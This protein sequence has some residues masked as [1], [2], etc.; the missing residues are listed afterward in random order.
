MA[1]R[2]PATP[3][4]RRPTPAAFRRARAAL[5]GEQTRILR[6]SDEAR[7]REERLVQALLLDEY[8][9]VE[10]VVRYLEHAL[11]DAEDAEE[12]AHVG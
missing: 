4:L 8:T 12:M 5:L 6:L 10:S 7:L 3:A 9:E 11:D 1:D 2:T